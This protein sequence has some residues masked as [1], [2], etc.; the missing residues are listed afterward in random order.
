MNQ[1]CL[2]LTAM[3]M[4]LLEQ[5]LNLARVINL[6]YY[7]D[8]DG[9]TLVIG[10]IFSLATHSTLSIWYLNN[11]RDI[12]PFYEIYILVQFMMSECYNTWPSFDEYLHCYS[13]DIEHLLLEQICGHKVSGFGSITNKFE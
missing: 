4:A 1:E 10:R 2:R 11:N 8:E 3:P 7:K 12:Y 9:N 13:F 6:M 5:V